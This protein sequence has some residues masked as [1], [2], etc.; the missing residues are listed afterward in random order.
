MFVC[1]RGCPPPPAAEIAASERLLSMQEVVETKGRQAA[2]LVDE[3]YNRWTN[4]NS[5]V[6]RRAAEAARKRQEVLNRREA[7][8][9]CG[10]RAAIT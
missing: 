9:L 1:G 8:Q 6:Q 5:S 4:F 7:A 2:S 3:A 10:M